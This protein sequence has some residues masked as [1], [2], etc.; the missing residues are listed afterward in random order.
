M[1]PEKLIDH[2]PDAFRLDRIAVSRERNAL[3]LWSEGGRRASI[4]QV[5]EAYLGAFGQDMEPLIP[6]P[7]TVRREIEETARRNSDAISLMD[8]GISAGSF[9]FPIPG[10]GYAAS[11]ES[12]HWGPMIALSELAEMKYLKARALIADRRFNAA[13]D[14]AIGLCR[15]GHMLCIGG[16]CSTLFTDGCI[17]QRHGFRLMVELAECPGVPHA[18]MNDLF[19]CVHSAH[20]SRNSFLRSFF[21]EILLVL[22]H[23]VDG[24]RDDMSV[25]D[26]V[27]AIWG[28]RRLSDELRFGSDTN[29]GEGAETSALDLP[30]VQIALRSLLRGHRRLFDK[31]ETI[32]LLAEQFQFTAEWFQNEP[33]RDLAELSD[34][35][36]ASDE[37]WPN[38]FRIAD[39][40]EATSFNETDMAALRTELQAA[41][42]PVGRLLAWEVGEVLRKKLAMHL[43]WWFD[44]AFRRE[45]MVVI[46]AIWLYAYRFTGLPQSLQDLVDEGIAETVPEDPVSKQPFLYS[47]KDQV[48]LSNGAETVPQWWSDRMIRDSHGRLVW[49]VRVPKTS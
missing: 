5:R 24:L 32:Q 7:D 47:W 31:S 8:E 37:L 19:D 38:A 12:P 35:A 33:L 21:G 45:A 34:T 2:V 40:S 29:E 4:G 39:V 3:E 16:G 18:V 23:T 42:N 41:V 25:A 26:I 1:P 13:S 27:S 6:L 14:E 15:M 17:A 30:A 43:F 44:M 28:Q 22:T 9:L 46:L 11:C 10:F 20:S 48:I 36:Q 49:K